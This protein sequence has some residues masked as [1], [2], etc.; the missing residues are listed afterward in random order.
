MLAYNAPGTRLLAV[1]VSYSAYDEAKTDAAKYLIARTLVKMA[2][3]M[4]LAKS[5]GQSAYPAKV[6]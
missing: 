6:L 5:A 2:R 1:E 3:I 4:L